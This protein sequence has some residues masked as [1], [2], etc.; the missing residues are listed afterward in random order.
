[1]NSRQKAKQWPFPRHKYFTR[2]LRTAAE[3]WFR[4]RKLTAHPRM[5]YCLA[6][7]NDWKSNII[8]DEVSDYVA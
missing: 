3:A 5:P 4:D 7:W 2:E 8:L 1:M 6:D